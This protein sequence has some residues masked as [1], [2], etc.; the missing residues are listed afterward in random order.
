MLTDKYSEGYPG[1][2]YYGGQ[3]CTDAIENI[4]RDRAK[5]RPKLVLCGFSSYPRYLD[6]AAFKSIADEVGA[7]TMA[8]VSHIGGLIAAGVK[9]NPMDFGFDAMT[10][11][12]HKTC[13]VRAPA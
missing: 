3:E 10:T 9:D 4:A 1:R 7:M 13:V 12:A 11:T 6:Y 8:D 2:R 5:H